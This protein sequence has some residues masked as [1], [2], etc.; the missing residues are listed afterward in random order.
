MINALKHIR[1]ILIHKWWV[2]YYCCK[3]GLYWRGIVHDLSKFHPVEFF[4]SIKYYT[5]TN[6]P[7]NNC[8]ADKGYSMAW[9]HHRGRNKH[10]YEYWCD[11]FDKGTTCVPM[12]YVYATEMICDYLAAGKAYNGRTFTIRNEFDWWINSKRDNCKMH[13]Y[14]KDYVTIMLDIMGNMER[15]NTFSNSDLRSIS[16]RQYKLTKKLLKLWEIIEK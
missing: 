14:T 9:F 5:G 11:N 10:H 3:F 8:K 6:S 1:T 16:K 15:C 12:P 13:E 7:I 4:E 2:F